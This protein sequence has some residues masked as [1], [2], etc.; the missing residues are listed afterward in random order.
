MCVCVSTA[1]ESSGSGVQSRLMSDGVCV[2]AGGAGGGLRG[3]LASSNL[4]EL[5]AFFFFHEMINDPSSCGKGANV[6]TKSYK[7]VDFAFVLFVR[8]LQ[9][10][11][12]STG[13]LLLCGPAAEGNVDL[14]IYRQRKQVGETWGLVMKS[15]MQ[16]LSNTSKWDLKLDGPNTAGTSVGGGWCVLVGQLAGMS[17]SQLQEMICPFSPPL[18]PLLNQG[19]SGGRG[20]LHLL[21]GG[22]RMSC[23]W[24]E[25]RHAERAVCWR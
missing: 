19:D 2:W 18:A 24:M 4:L 16:H 25:R 6:A 8:K 11:A 20:Q 9:K 5:N 7:N 12:A 21:A 17:S 22:G 10:N 15:R 3:P 1:H 13:R 23:S 14:F